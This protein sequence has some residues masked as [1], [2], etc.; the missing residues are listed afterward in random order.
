LRILYTEKAYPARK[1]FPGSDMQDPGSWILNPGSNI[2]ERGFD[3]EDP[4]WRMLDPFSRIQEPIEDPGSGIVGDFG[5]MDPVSDIPGWELC[6]ILYPG[7][8]I[9]D[10][11]FGLYRETYLGWRWGGDLYLC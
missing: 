6:R 8:G 9:L 11:G 1:R 4:G 7:S 10:G 3:I 5:I 2:L